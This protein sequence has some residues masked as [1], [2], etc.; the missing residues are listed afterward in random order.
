MV[1]LL[2]LR[3]CLHFG[4]LIKLYRTISFL[5]I[6]EQDT[7]WY[8]KINECFPLNIWPNFNV[9]AQSD[10]QHRSLGRGGN[11]REQQQQIKQGGS[12][13]N[14]PL[15]SQSIDRSEILRSH[16]RRSCH[17]PMSESNTSLNAVEFD[18][19]RNS[20][21][22]GQSISEANFLVL[23]S[24]KKTNDFFLFLP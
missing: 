15:R 12:A 6:D 11:R 14:W 13:S 1:N 2:Y 19:V 23:I 5:R 22:K 20:K 8:F 4:S 24:S 9:S 18:E 3:L 16:V 7:K 17:L 10:H 21:T